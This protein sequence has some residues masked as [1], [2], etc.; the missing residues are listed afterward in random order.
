MIGIIILLVI[1]GMT[2]GGLIAWLAPKL[3]GGGA[4]G[5]VGFLDRQNW[6]PSEEEIALRPIR[7]LIDQDHY[8]E[9]LAGLEKL[10]DQHRPTY[11]ALLLKAKLHYHIGGI[12]QTTAALVQSIGLSHTTEQQLAVM[13]LLAQIEEQQPPAS[14]PPAGGTRRLSLG[15]ELILFPPAAKDR[16]LHKTIPPGSYDVEETLHGKLLWLKLANEDW[17]NAEICWEAARASLPPPFVPQKRAIFKRKSRLDQQ[18]EAQALLKEANIFIRQEDWPRALPLLQK[19]SASHPDHYEIAY[20]W[21]QA[22][23]RTAD[24]ATAAA[25]VERI[26]QQSQWTPSEQQMLLQLKRPL[27]TTKV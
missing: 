13:E 9:A 15:L 12:D 5:L 17:G 26:L 19:A 2:L 20:R 24:D 1:V 3:A 25:A 27:P 6:T 23:R 7:R 18:A 11:E 16:S 4:A 10:L 22:V 14:H 21:A 8:R